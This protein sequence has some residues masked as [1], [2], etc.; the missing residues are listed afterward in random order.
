MNIYSVGQDTIGSD[1]DI[2]HVWHQTIIYTII[3]I[4]YQL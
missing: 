2:L 3:R 1:K 4:Y